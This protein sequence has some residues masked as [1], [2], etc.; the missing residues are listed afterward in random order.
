MFDSE[1]G[2]LDPDH[3]VVAAG[4][5][6]LAVC[7]EPAPV[8]RAIL[9][10]HI[11]RV[12]PGIVLGRVQFAQVQKLSLHGAAAMHAQTLAHR[13]VDV[14]LAVFLPRASLQEHRGG[15]SHD[16]QPRV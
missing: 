16:P 6:A 8:A 5:G 1:A 14:L 12:L 2:E 11:E 7:E 13:I 9:V 3:A 15:I 10:E 4:C